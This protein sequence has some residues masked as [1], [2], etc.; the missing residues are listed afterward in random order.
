MTPEL[1]A[2]LSDYLPS[3]ELAPMLDCFT[4]RRVRKHR[5]YITPGKSCDSIAF[6]QKGSFR[7]YFFD[8]KGKEVTTWFSFE[9]M[10]ITDMLAFYTG[11]PASF[12][13]QALEPC[14]TYAIKKSQLEQLYLEHPVYQAFGRKFAEEALTMLMHRTLALQTQ[15]PEERYLELLAQPEFMQ[16]IP[17]KYLA[18]YLGVT[19]TSLS[20]I[21]K[22]IQ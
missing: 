16:K 21:R 6:I 5:F 7:V 19:D 2:F 4:L 11:N 12:Y 14:E 17:L 9:G 3:V 22:R 10:V 15:S 20:R 8:R 1:T 13:A 18:S